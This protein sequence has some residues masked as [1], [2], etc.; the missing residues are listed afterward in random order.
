VG[1]WG[2]HIISCGSQ[3]YTIAA[4][5]PEFG[6]WGSGGRSP[7]DAEAFSLNYRIR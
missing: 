7:P 5:D 1:L 6:D 3:S 4:T 2:G